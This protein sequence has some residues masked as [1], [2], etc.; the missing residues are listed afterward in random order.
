VILSSLRRVNTALFATTFVLACS[1]DAAPTKRAPSAN[2]TPTTS[3]ATPATSDSLAGSVDLGGGAYTPGVLS[4]VGSVTGNIKLDGSAPRDTTTI[5]GDQP[6][7]GRTPDAATVATAKGVSNAIVWI[8]GIKSGKDLPVEKRAELSSEKCAL[9]PRVQ[10]VVAGTTVN[11]F[12]DDRLIH[13][14]VFIRGAHD[15]LSTMTFFNG[16]ELVASERLATKSGIVEVRC[17]LHPWMRGY[18]AVFDHPYFA[19]TGNDGRFTIDSLAPGPHKLMVWH[20][21]M[22]QPMAQQIQIAAN[23]TAKVDLA[24]R[25][26][27]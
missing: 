14:L 26:V 2:R 12:N 3:G 5:T 24:I 21:G 18:V 4:A 9:D 8:A 27:R 16:G 19:V 23:G 13:T 10:A 15:T 25:V 11:V 17:A 6:I 1:T 7:C 22:A 20:E